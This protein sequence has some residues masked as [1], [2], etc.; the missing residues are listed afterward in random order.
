MQKETSKEQDPEKWWRGA[1]KVFFSSEHQNQLGYRTSLP[2][3]AFFPA[4]NT[5]CST[6]QFQKD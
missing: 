3:Q 5:L 1:D 2:K 6:A 4:S